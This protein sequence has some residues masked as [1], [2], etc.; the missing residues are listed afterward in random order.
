MISNLHLNGPMV[1][2]K[3]AFDPI[4]PGKAGY[5]DFIQA[6]IQGPVQHFALESVPHIDT[7]FSV[8]GIMGLQFQRKLGEKIVYM[9]L[10]ELTRKESCYLCLKK[11]LV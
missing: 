1:T 9:R 7:L 11:I 2:L 6:F 3:D 10:Q 8:L 5:I 4:E